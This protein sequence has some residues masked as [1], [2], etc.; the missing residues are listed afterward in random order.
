LTLFLGTTKY[1][2]TLPAYILT[3]HILHS[4]EIAFLGKVQLNNISNEI[5]GKV[6][7]DA[8]WKSTCPLDVVSLRDDEKF[9]SL[10]QMNLFLLDLR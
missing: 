5:H 7:I 2:G 10:V 4:Q 3:I 9:K 1:G 8:L 6:I